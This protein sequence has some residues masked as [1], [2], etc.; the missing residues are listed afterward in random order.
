MKIQSICGIILTTDKLEKM[1]AFYR[2]IL[3]LPLKKEE[4]GDMDVHYG[5]DLGTIHFAIHPLSDFGETQK[6]S[7]TTKIAFNVC[8]PASA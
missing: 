4:H 3:N 1:A 8:L 2:N 5:C 7:S 6:G